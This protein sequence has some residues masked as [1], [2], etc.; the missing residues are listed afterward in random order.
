MIQ[1]WDFINPLSLKTSIC[2]KQEASLLVALL[3]SCI[4]CQIKYVRSASC[5]DTNYQPLAKIIGNNFIEVVSIELRWKKLRIYGSMSWN[6]VHLSPVGP[7]ILVN[8]LCRCR[9]PLFE[10]SGTFMQNYFTSLLKITFFLRKVNKGYGYGMKQCTKIF[11]V[12]H[13]IQPKGGRLLELLP[14]QFF[15]I[16]SKSTS[17]DPLC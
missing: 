4:R 10:T 5:A 1:K 12:Y 9:Y 14:I 8:W 2:C 15:L 17:K 6:M 16:K 13:W 3:F 7:A 11:L